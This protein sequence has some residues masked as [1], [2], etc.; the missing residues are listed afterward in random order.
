MT[1]PRLAIVVKGFPRLSE[2]F[3]ARELAALERRG[4]VFSLHALRQPGAD[5]ALTGY[6]PAGGVHYLPEY[7][8]E[9][10]AAVAGAILTAIR[11]PGFR[12][13]VASLAADFRRDPTRARLRRFGQ[14]AV[15]ASA[16]AGRAQHIH[17]HFAHSPGSVTRYAAMMLGITYSLSTHA[18]DVWTDPDW[19]LAAKMRGA[20]FVA[21]CNTAAQARLAALCPTA[22]IQLIRHGIDE[23]LLAPL[24]PPS[25]HDG[26]DAPHAVRL[27]CVARAVSKKGVDTLVDAI[28]LLKGRLHVHVDHYGAGPL[29]P[30]LQARAQQLGVNEL[31]TFHGAVSHRA[32][33]DAMDRADLLVFP[34]RVGEDGDRDGVPNVILE[35][36]ARGLCV[37]ACDA[38]GVSEAI[39]DGK[40]GMLVVSGTVQELAERLARCIADPLLRHQLSC[41]ARE[42]NMALFDARVGHDRLAAL[43]GRLAGG[44]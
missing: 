29:L 35:A 41:A 19:D 17:C 34:A 40:T 25:G 37:V 42:T 10:P 18:R 20:T 15:L 27:A 33:I 1:V 32:V 39:V 21:C 13:S 14:A 5:A 16:L 36:Q 22:D 7:L 2:T 31:F 4:L 38:G 6:R 43:L 3:I 8:H 12:A 26:R 24:R 30:A 9:A 28:A 11:L 44:A 23:G